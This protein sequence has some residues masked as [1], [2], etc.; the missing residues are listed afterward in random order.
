MATEQDFAWTDQNLA[1]VAT[2]NILEGDDQLNQFDAIFLK[3]KSAGPVKLSSLPYFP[4]FEAAPEDIEGRSEQ[5]ARKFFRFLITLYTGR[6]ESRQ[7]TVREV[8]DTFAALFA[9][10]QARMKDLAAAADR[11][12]KFSNEA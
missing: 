6:K 11:F 9:S 3:F 5:M 2:Y 12:L 4:K 1:C 8:L 7:T 10:D